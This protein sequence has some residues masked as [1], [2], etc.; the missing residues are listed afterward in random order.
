MLTEKEALL[1]VDAA[2]KAY[3]YGRGDWPLRKVEIK[4]IHFLIPVSR[5]QG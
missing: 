2:Q 1:A 5:P 3:N 4:I